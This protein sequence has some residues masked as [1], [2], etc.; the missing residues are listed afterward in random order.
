MNI[1][2]VDNLEYSRVLREPSHVFNSAAFAE[3]NKSKC[4]GV[5][6]L[7]FNDNKVRFGLILGEVA[8]GLSSPFSAPFGG[9]ESLSRSV[10]LEHVDEAVECLKRYAQEARMTLQIT[11]PPAI[12]DETFVA[13]QINSLFRAGFSWQAYDLSHVFRTTQFSRYN[14]I[15]DRSMRKNLATAARLGLSF[16]QSSGSPQDDDLRTAYAIIKANRESRGFPLR[17]TLDAVLQTA[18]VVPTDVFLVSKNASDIAAAIVYR[19]APR[20]AQVIYWGD[21]PGHSDARPMNYLAREVF[22]S[23]ASIAGIDFVDVGPSTE[24]SIPNF[25]LCNFKENIGCQIS[26][27]VTCEYPPRLRSL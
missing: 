17:M 14:E 7:L 19:V 1:E 13:Q 25:G 22:G 26:P 18:R 27:K 3:L 24:R 5:H 2:R 16:C 8:D 21:K 6:Y 15:I 11:L 20:I 9:F 12:Y 10:H 23:Y 4:D